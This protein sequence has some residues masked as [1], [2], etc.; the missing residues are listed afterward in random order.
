MGD[1][2]APTRKVKVNYLLIDN[3]RH[4]GAAVNVFSQDDYDQ[5][6]LSSDIRARM[7]NIFPY[8]LTGGIVAANAAS[9]VSMTLKVFQS[10]TK[11]IEGTPEF[12]Y[13]TV[14]NVLSASDSQSWSENHRNSKPQSY[15]I[16]TVANNSTISFPLSK[17]EGL[18]AFSYNSALGQG[19]I[20]YRAVTG[21]TEAALYGATSISN[22]AVT[23]GASPAGSASTVTFSIDDTGNM[24]V[25][26]QRGASLDIT[27]NQLV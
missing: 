8:S 25:N 21:S 22:V 9:L 14:G 24:W 15:A 26:N 5:V 20:K 13:T 18:V 17:M 16:K 7:D 12:L 27:F 2:A 1:D 10:S 3:I 23:T 4:I 11:W 19:I 6:A